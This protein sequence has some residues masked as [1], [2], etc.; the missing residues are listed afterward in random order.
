MNKLLKVFDASIYS[1]LPPRRNF[2]YSYDPRGIV[3]VL[4]R[5]NG[6]TFLV[7]SAA[8]RW[9]IS[10]GGVAMSVDWSHPALTDVDDSLIAL[11]KHHLTDQM[12]VKSPPTVQRKFRAFLNF[13]QELDPD[14][15]IVSLLKVF[16][17]LY[18]EGSDF[19]H[20]LRVFYNWG[21]SQEI[22]IFD[23]QVQNIINDLPAPKRS[24]Y[25]SIFL[26]QNYIT[27]DEETRILRHIDI[28]LSGIENFAENKFDIFRYRVLQDATILL[29]V[30]EVAPRPLQIFMLEKGDLKET[31]VNSD[32]HFFSLRLRR[33]KNKHLSD[34]YTSPR[35]ISVRLGKAMK[36]LMRLN[37]KFF[38]EGDCQSAAPCFL[39]SK[40]ERLSTTSV[41]HIVSEALASIFGIE[42]LDVEGALTPF[43]HHLGQS[44]A[45]QGATAAVIADRL[46]HSTEVAAR[47]YI[48]STPEIGKIKT[49]ALG[50]NGTYQHLIGALL[51]GSIK[52]RS[53]VDDELSIVRGTVGFH[54]I[55]GIGACDVNG[56]CHSNPIY[57]CY[58]CRKFHPFIDFPHDQVVA[59]LQEQVVTFFNSTTDLQHSR[60]VVQLELAI[61]SAKAISKE[62]KKREN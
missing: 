56:H 27:P 15:S 18:V 60:P 40:G 31:N 28:R 47:A 37:L 51:T 39:N 26:Q 17:R 45:D 3:R 53:E 29:L 25:D 34:E 13:A 30:Y 38:P 7:D 14:L 1:N 50:E 49:R 55:E 35:E 23:S 54:Y 12:Q 61:E 20:Y 10:Y 11:W 58:T 16:S 5:V 48:A 6:D 42:G 9:E 52:H 46:G 33:N 22:E 43:R 8:N 36:K 59:A 4:G 62:C 41:S 21:V 44:L 2:C 24:S 57:A 32:Q 19:F